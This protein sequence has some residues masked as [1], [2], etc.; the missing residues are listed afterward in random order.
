MS[1][2]FKSLSMP[3]VSACIFLY[4][5]KDLN[6]KSYHMTEIF[7]PA[8]YYLKPSQ[9]QSKRQ[10]DYKTKTDPQAFKYCLQSSLCFPYSIPFKYSPHH[11]RTHKTNKMHSRQMQEHSPNSHLDCI[12]YLFHVHITLSNKNI[13]LI[14]IQL[15]GFGRTGD[16]L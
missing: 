10:L 1:K 13:S 6:T 4:L 14:R 2:D 16:V 5:C 7:H 12:H 9:S 3:F 11:Q 8:S 15:I